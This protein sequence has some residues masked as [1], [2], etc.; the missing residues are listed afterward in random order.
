MPA[1]VHA[2]IH[3]PPPGADTPPGAE[4]PPPQQTPPQEQTLRSS[5]CWEI[6]ATL[7]RYASYWNAY[8]LFSIVSSKNHHR[9]G[10][11]DS[12][13]DAGAARHH[14]LHDEAGIPPG[15]VPFYQL[16]RPVALRL[17]PPDQHRDVV[18][19]ADYL[20]KKQRREVNNVVRQTTS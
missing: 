4:P 18:V 14:V 10:Y 15:V 8:L 20:Q 16:L 19:S 9:W 2:G 12:F 13:H 11:L 7:G 3:P 5:A 17:L 1:L 6:R